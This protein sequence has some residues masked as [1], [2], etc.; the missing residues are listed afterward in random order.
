MALPAGLGDRRHCPFIKD[1]A[2]IVREGRVTD[3]G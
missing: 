1:I 2:D 3:F